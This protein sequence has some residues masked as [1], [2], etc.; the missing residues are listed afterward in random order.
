MSH[1]E[2]MTHVILC[3]NNFSKSQ[4]GTKKLVSVELPARKLVL[5]ILVCYCVE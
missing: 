4:L 5:D 1:E 3:K 2:F